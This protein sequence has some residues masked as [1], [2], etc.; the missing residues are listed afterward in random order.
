M[1]VL[2][3][4]ALVLPD[5][6]LSPG[7]LTINDGRIVE[8]RPDL[9]SGAAAFGFPGHYI[10]PGFIDVHVHGVAGVDT[11]DP[12]VTGC[13]R[14]DRRDAAALRGHGVLSDH[15]G[16]YADRAPTR[17]GSSATCARIADAPARRVS[18]RR[19]SK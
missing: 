12:D 8:I 2:S 5:R 17:A 10:V 3:G 16:L 19:I 15:R 4:A 14:P 6:I 18:C 13:H 7:T 1:I 11:L 9:P